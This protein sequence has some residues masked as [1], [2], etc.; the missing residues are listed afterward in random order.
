MCNWCIC[1]GAALAVIPSMLL[2]RF[3]NKQKPAVIYT[4]AGSSDKCKCLRVLNN[5]GNYDNFECYDCHLIKDEQRK[6]AELE[7]LKRKQDPNIKWTLFRG[8]PVKVEQY[9]SYTTSTGHCTL[10]DN[11]CEFVIAVYGDFTRKP[12]TLI[13][14]SKC[15]RSAIT[16]IYVCAVCTGKV[17]Q[18]HELYITSG[19]P[20]RIIPELCDYQG[21]PLNEPV[22]WK[23]LCKN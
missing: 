12:A 3:L 6:L 15:D 23:R 11:K 4:N 19:N 1:S 16:A 22:M 13:D 10:C 7:E 20:L 14:I 17:R 5:S 9:M 18:I 2:I 21:N 8:R